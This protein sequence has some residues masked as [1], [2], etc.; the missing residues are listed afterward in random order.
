MSSA[1]RHNDPQ[2][3]LADMLDKLLADRWSCRAFRPDP[4]PR[5]TV[6]SVI[7]AAQRAPSWCNTPAVAADRHLRGRDGQVPPCTS[8]AHR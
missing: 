4:L 6:A 3:E 1:A 8:G 7:E 2:G 5:E